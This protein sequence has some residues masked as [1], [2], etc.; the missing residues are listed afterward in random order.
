MT[1]LRGF[2]GVLAFACAACAPAIN[3][4]DPAGPRFGT[5]GRTER[6]GLARAT[7]TELVVAT[8]N[9]KYGRRVGR[10]I[11]V[12]RTPP[13]RSADVILLQEVDDED[14]ERVAAALNLE[15]VYYPGSIHPTENRHFGSAILSAWP[16]E[17]DWKVILPHRSWSRGQQR[18]A[19]AAVLRTGDRR[20]RVYSLH[21]ELPLNITAGRSRRAGGAHP[22]RRARRDRAR[23]DRRRLQ[24]PRR[25]LH[26]GAR[27]IQVADPRG[28]TDGLGVPGRPRVRARPGGAHRRG[29]CG[30]PRGERPPARLDGPGPPRHAPARA[31]S[32]ASPLL[33]TRPMRRA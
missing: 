33:T 20:V 8:F 22:L 4:T 13:L 31:G 24:R 14:V 29:R 27:W 15:Y 7:P 17:R 28:G 23:G 32:R 19:T 1:G 2:C 11:E 16:I 6:T 10:A 12:L 21:L 25:R 9:I 3:L 18:T 26:P 30:H 5:H